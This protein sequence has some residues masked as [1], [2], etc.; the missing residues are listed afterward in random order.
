[1][2]REELRKISAFC[3]ERGISWH[4][5]GENV[6]IEYEVTTERV[7]RWVNSCIVTGFDHLVATLQFNADR[8]TI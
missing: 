3:R 4:T 7:A 1:M 6:I 8:Q 5:Y 2:E